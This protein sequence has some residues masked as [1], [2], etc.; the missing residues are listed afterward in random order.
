MKYIIM[1][2]GQGNRWDNFNNIP[3]HL[4]EINNETL[5]SRTVRLLKEYDSRYRYHYYFS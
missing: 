5:L 4:I 3:K 1:A 2:D